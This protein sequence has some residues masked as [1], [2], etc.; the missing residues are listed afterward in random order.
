LN[1]AKKKK[2]VAEKRISDDLFVLPLG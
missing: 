2:K 1:W